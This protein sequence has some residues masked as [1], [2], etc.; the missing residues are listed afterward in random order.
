MVYVRLSGCDLELASPFK[1]LPLGSA[2]TVHKAS[3]RNATWKKK[4]I[5]EEK[6]KTFATKCPS[7]C[8]QHCLAV[9]FSVLP[10][11]GCRVCASL[12]SWLCSISSHSTA[13]HGGPAQCPHPLGSSQLC[14]LPRATTV[15]QKCACIPHRSYGTYLPC[16][17]Y[18]SYGICSYPPCVLYCS[19]SSCIYP[20]LCPVLS[21]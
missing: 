15:L 11:L 7:L 10:P 1:F 18:H 13:G 21:S 8:R 2:H 3:Q 19:V 20:V 14:G 6:K 9:V 16:I 5:Q 12:L 4:H 17:P